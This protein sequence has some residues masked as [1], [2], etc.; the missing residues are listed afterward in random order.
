MFSI[1]YL[2]VSAPHCSSS[3]RCVAATIGVLDLR[4]GRAFLGGVPD[5]ACQERLGP[6]FDDREHREI[7]I[8]ASS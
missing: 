1:I 5:I 2:T 4:D 3:P 8:G 6:L 7:L